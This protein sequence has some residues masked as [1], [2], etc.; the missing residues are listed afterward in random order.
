MGAAVEGGASGGPGV[1]V[2]LLTS[3]RER[4]GIARYSRDLRDALAPLVEVDLVPI[5][6]WPPEHE[7]VERLR[8]ADVVHLQHEYSFWSTAFPP[9][10]TYYDGLARFRR[11]GRLVITAHTIADAET[12]VA[13]K[14]W[15]LKPV[16]KRGA[17]RMRPSLSRD[18]E[19]GPFLL[20]DRVVVH[21]TV[22]ARNLEERLGRP[23]GVQFWP[24]PVPEWS[25]PAGK[26]GPLSQQFGF[27]GRRLV[28]IFGFI[29]PEKNYWLALRAMRRVKKK[30]P[31]ALLVIAGGARD[32]RMRR[33]ADHLVALE[34]MVEAAPPRRFPR[35]REPVPAVGYQAFQR[36]LEAEEKS[37]LLTLALPFRVT[38][39]LT[40]SDA[41]AVLEQTEIALLPYH[42]ATGSYAAG[43]ALAAGCALLTSDLPAFAEPL[44]ALRFRPE[45]VEDLADKLSQ[46]LEDDVE[47]TYLIARSRRYA[48]ENSWARSAERHVGL[49]QELLG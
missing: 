8:G 7:R 35:L 40:D 19:A 15:G 32:E 22:A 17:L 38:G 44:P 14:G 16:V 4:C 30:H 27:H 13:A 23:G 20:A 39:Y 29:T 1:R 49:Y 42:T 2:A 46:L 10:R 47:R 6:P 34:G 18:I 26:W 28:T 37:R 45:D 43:A 12:V 36:E 11:P 9:P 48:Q 5:H 21:S 3:D 24:M 33:L 41:R 31:D 25:A